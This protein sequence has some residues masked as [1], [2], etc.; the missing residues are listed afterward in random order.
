MTNV[1]NVP[2]RLTRSDTSLEGGEAL[3]L[4][5]AQLSRDVIKMTEQ[6]ALLLLAFAEHL[7][8]LREIETGKATTTVA[9][10]DSSESQR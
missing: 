1:T 4:Y 2:G 9:R 7:T 10:K 8:L 6:S 5:L 3:D